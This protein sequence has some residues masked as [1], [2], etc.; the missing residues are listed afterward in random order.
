MCK[1]AKGVGKERKGTEA[2]LFLEG[3]RDW[4]FTKESFSS[5]PLGL[6]LYPPIRH[7]DSL[8]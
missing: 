1:G 2:V 8:A 3:F 5:H 4:I 7:S 6:P